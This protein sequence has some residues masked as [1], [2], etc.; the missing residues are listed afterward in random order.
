MAVYK[1]GYE[2]YEGPLAPQ[3]SRPLIIARY[4]YRRVF[5]SR[6]LMG[7]LLLCCI[8]PAVAA[9]LIYLPHNAAVA[10]LFGGKRLISIDSLF[11][12]RFMSWQG[13]MAFLLTGFLGP[14]LV[15]PDLVNNALPLYFCRPFSRAE[16]V[17]GKMSVLAILISFI[18]WIPGWVLVGFEAYLDGAAWFAQNWWLL[19]SLF[20]GSAIWTVALCLLAMATSA[21]VKWRIVAGALIFGL[22]FVVGGFGQAINATLHT[23][24]GSMVNLTEVVGTI[25]SWLFDRPVE[26]KLPI[27]LAWAALVAFCGLF[28][29]LLSSKLRA[30]RVER[31]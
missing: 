19:A 3:W 24:L 4:A 14:G 15:S 2:R 31:S 18:T 9:V 30:F 20:I 26:L 5:E 29:L 10:G 13:G 27:G 25:W 8:Y 28:Y 22:I 21:W 7:F 16:Y 11:F 17:I 1:R 23:R 12:F 6:F